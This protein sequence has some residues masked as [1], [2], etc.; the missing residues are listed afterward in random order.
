MLDLFFEVLAKTE[1]YEEAYR[2]VA[3][4]VSRRRLSMRGEAMSYEEAAEML[5]RAVDVSERL[6][7]IKDV[8]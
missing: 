3:S 7:R 6:E 1:S 2:Q 8:V 4:E 5:N